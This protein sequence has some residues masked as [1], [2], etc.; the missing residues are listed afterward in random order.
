MSKFDSSYKEERIRS[1][2]RLY[3]SKPEVQLAMLEFAKGR[4][5]VPRY[6]EAFGK[7]PDMLQY[8][9]DIMGAVLKGATSFHGSQEI[10]S[11]PLRIDSEMSQGE[12]A[13][14]RTSWDL[15]IDI[16]SPYLDY[17]KIAAK[18]VLEVFEKYK[19]ESYTVKYSGSKGF[20]IMVPGSA[21]PQVFKGQVMREMFPEWPR[22]ITEFILY[23]IKPVYNR[24]IAKLGINFEALQERTKLSKE[25]LLATPCPQCG[26]PSTKGNI[27]IFE[28]DR[29]KTRIE[30]KDPKITKRKLKC[31]DPTCPGYFNEIETKEYF[32][33][34]KCK[35][36]SFD[37]THISSNKVVYNANSTPSY[38]EEFKEEFS[39]DRLGSLDLVLVSSRHLFRMPYSLHEKTALASVV[40]KKEQ[41]D[42][43]TPRDADPLKVTIIHYNTQAKPNEAIDLLEA[44]LV[45]KNASQ[46]EEEKALKKKY[47]SYETIDVTGVTEDQ[48]PQPIKKLLKGLSEG[49]KRGLFI[50]ITFLRSLNF[51][52]DYIN[53]RIREWNKL[54][55]PPLK[56]GYVKSQIDWH[57]RQKKKILPPNYSNASFYK[58]LNLLDKEPTVKN[59][60]VEV[61]RKAKKMRE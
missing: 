39:G 21:F 45:W 40:L 22:A 50:L 20:H 8:P 3:Y 49:R 9:A 18:L 38:S 6:F 15:L 11:D 17:S 24:A 34:E 32:Y 27:I 46:N 43:F 25:D 19:I 4:E 48:F 53:A 54:N 28:C 33:C 5:V 23:T 36:S 56:E 1:I 61:L 42:T 57:L 55:A 12:L 58:D 31:I 60:I 52:P 51:T 10:W 2:T 7:R 26:S 59:P 35:L 13:N 16:D 14:L 29:C 37:K 47:N 44:A 30:R 41:I